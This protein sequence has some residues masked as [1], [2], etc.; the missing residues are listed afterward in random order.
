MTAASLPRDSFDGPASS[1]RMTHASPRRPPECNSN[2]PYLSKRASNL[3]LTIMTF[4]S[5]HKAPMMLD[6]TQCSAELMELRKQ[7][8][9]AVN[10][11]Y[12][13]AMPTTAT[14]ARHARSEAPLQA[15]LTDARQCLASLEAA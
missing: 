1:A 4:W 9:I 14:M 7:R 10:W 6:R 2:A 3:M 13:S 11:E 8:L 5:L 15:A 12:C